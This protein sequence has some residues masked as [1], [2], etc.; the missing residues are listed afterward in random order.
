MLNP[1]K[2]LPAIQA[3]VLVSSENRSNV[4]SLDEGAANEVG[5]YRNHHVSPL[6]RSK[7]QILVILFII[8]KILEIK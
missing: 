7:Q 4:K 2:N 1:F 6:C 5:P 3:S 8:L